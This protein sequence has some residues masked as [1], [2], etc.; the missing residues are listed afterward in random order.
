MQSNLV[1]KFEA[2]LPYVLEEESP[3]LT[4]QTEQIDAM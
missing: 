1:T 3:A 4:E 2:D